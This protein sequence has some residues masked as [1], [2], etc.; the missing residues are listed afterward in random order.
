MVW[1]AAWPYGNGP[2]RFGLFGRGTAGSP[3]PPAR[4]E[5]AGSHLCNGF[6]MGGPGHNTGRL[7]PG[8][9]PSWEG[10]PRSDFAKAVGAR[11]AP[12]PLVPR[13]LPRKGRGA[14]L[15]RTAEARAPA[16]FVRT[17][18]GF[19]PPN[20]AAKGNDPGGIRGS[21]M[22]RDV[23]APDSA[24]LGLKSCGRARAIRWARHPPAKLAGAARPEVSG[25]LSS[26]RGRA[27]HSWKASCGHSPKGL[28]GP[29]RTC[30]AV[31]MRA[32]HAMPSANSLEEAGETSGRS[33]KGRVQRDL[34]QVHRWRP[35]GPCGSGT[36]SIGGKTVPSQTF[37][38][39]PR[40]RSW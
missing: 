23:V 36:G 14:W 15:A 34:V 35:G 5:G 17:W 38:R 10:S 39:V 12:P 4:G 27:V 2:A 1:R 37:A 22:A 29:G 25:R 40:H 6:R 11:H 20:K 32:G 33:R 8:G 3:H 19:G 21:A 28:S 7:G 18:R 24:T 31:P 30:Q 13:R 26:G 16:S 9:C